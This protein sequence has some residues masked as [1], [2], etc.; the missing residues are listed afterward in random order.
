MALLQ[1]SSSRASEPDM[2]D[3]CEIDYQ[4]QLIF[5]GLDDFSPNAALPHVYGGQFGP[6][7]DLWRH[8]V[9]A[10][11]C[12][13][14]RGGLLEMF[15]RRDILADGG[16]DQLKNILTA[17][18]K[19]SHFDVEIIWNAL[20]FSATEKLD[21]ILDRFELRSWEAL[22][23]DLNPGFIAELRGCYRNGAF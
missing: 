8:E 4:R 11:L 21:E 22:K 6:S 10:F 15:Y 2:F 16:I 9:V 5:S 17:G 13:N 18:D 23:L 19:E 1:N 7:P 20:Y 12:V 3:F 14:V